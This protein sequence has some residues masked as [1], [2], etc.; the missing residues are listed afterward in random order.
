MTDGPRTPEAWGQDGARE[1]T[2]YRYLQTGPLQGQAWLRGLKVRPS[3]HGQGLVPL[4]TAP[5]PQLRARRADQISPLR[6]HRQPEEEGG[7]LD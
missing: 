4:L 5:P 3:V 1:C 6:P 7:D 2:E